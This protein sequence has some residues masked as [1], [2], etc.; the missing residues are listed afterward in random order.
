[1]Y[2]C[3]EQPEA[4]ARSLGFGG[5][6]TPNQIILGG[7]DDNFDR[8]SKIK[9]MTLS[10]CGTSLHAAQYAEKLMKK[11]AVF[12][13]VSSI[14]A[15]ETDAKDFPNVKDPSEAGL[16]VVS[17]SGETKDGRSIQCHAGSFMKKIHSI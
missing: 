1:M 15:A 8:L 3:I 14:D 17:Q 2:R 7:P 9:Y 16:I 10:A 5:R 12:D 6:L 11:L 13:W 4:I